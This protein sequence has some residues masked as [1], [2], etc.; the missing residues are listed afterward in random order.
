MPETTRV[1]VPLHEQSA[2]SL[3]RKLCGLCDQRLD[4]MKRSAK[5]CASIWHRDEC[6]WHARLNPP[7]VIAPTEEGRT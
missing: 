5:H 6:T 2:S 3:R 7:R 4:R 1:R